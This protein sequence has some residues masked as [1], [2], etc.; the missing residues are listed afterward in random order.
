[1]P[2]ANGLLIREILQHKKTLIIKFDTQI[3]VHAKI[4]SQLILHKTNVIEVH[5]SSMHLDQL[6]K[7]KELM[8]K[9]GRNEKLVPKA[10]G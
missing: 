3:Q 1:M 8:V 4:I 5:S 10:S 2:F 6:N 7:F 9:D